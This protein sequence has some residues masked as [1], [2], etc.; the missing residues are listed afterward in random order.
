MNAEKGHT[1]ARATTNTA[2]LD[3]GPVVAIFWNMFQYIYEA[4]QWQEDTYGPHSQ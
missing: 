3:K 2:S 1:A 4:Q